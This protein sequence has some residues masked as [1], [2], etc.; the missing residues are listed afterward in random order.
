M[1]SITVKSGEKLP[2]SRLIVRTNIMTKM[3]STAAIPRQVSVSPMLSVVVPVY[4]GTEEQRC[5]AA[6]AASHYSD[7]EV[8]VVDD[9]STQPVARRGNRLQLQVSASGGA[10]GPSSRS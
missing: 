5:L 4:N 8:L 1:C 9:G 7:F 3:S 6:L 10:G 2:Q